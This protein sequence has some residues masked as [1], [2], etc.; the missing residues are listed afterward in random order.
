MSLLWRALRILA[1]A[2]VLVLGWAVFDPRF[3]S[4][5]PTGEALQ[6]LVKPLG[7]MGPLERPV[8]GVLVTALGAALV[9]AALPKSVADRPRPKKPPQEPAPEPDGRFVRHAEAHPEDAARPPPRGPEAV[10]VLQPVETED[11]PSDESPSHEAE[12]AA[13]RARLQA[14]DDPSARSRL[15]DLLKK[16]GDLHEA[17]GRLGDAI[18]AYEESATLRRAVVAAAPDD[19]RELRWLWLTLEVLADC[20]EA[21]GQRSRASALYKEALAAGERSVAL[22]PEDAELAVRLVHTRQEIERLEVL[23]AV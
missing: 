4:G 15:A 22:A 18:E 23:L 20:R 2:G 14:G 3:L 12:V 7:S 1:A 8:W 16:S 10:A 19:V 21:R 11:G 6:T 13:E 9:L 17:D 5:Q